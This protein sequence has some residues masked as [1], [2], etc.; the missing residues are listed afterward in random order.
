MVA[1]N[2]VRF[3]VKP[4]CEQ[5]FIDAH[6][7]AATNFGGFRGGALV[8][9]GDRT[10]CFIGEWTSFAKI[11]QARPGMIALLDGMRDYLEDLGDGLGLTDPVSGERVVNLK[12][13]RTA[14][15]KKA[16]PKKAAT[17]KK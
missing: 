14:R 15:R 3:R 4:R 12:P 8:K 17:R 9:T 10:F 11:A 13:R 2:V 6:E 7:K 5:R 1:Y 16:A